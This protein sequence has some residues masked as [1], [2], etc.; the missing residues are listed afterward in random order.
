MPKK[1]N[2]LALSD[3]GED[4]DIVIQSKDED[5][6]E[7]EGL[8]EDEID[9]KSNPWIKA[10]S[11]QDILDINSEFYL[12][13]A[14]FQ[15]LSGEQRHFID[16]D[17]VRILQDDTTEMAD[18]KQLLITITSELRALTLASQ[19]GNCQD[20]FTDNPLDA[21]KARIPIDISA[22]ITSFKT[23]KLER[24]FVDMLILKQY[25]EEIRRF[26]EALQSKISV[27]VL[28]YEYDEKTKEGSYFTSILQKSVPLAKTPSGERRIPL[29]SY[30]FED[31][32]FSY[33]STNYAL[34]ENVSVLHDVKAEK[35]T[36]K[37]QNWIRKNCCRLTI[38]GKDFCGKESFRKDIKILIKSF[39][40]GVFEKNV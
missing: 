30:V 33:H 3:K 29:T 34:K 21:F 14:L 4:E 23:K 32:E 12:R 2:M 22:K 5:S 13:P 25:G 11:W 31:P 37:M 17:G 26:A 16:E 19:I 40:E 8:S 38:L 28:L 27:F 15:H 36:L 35:L 1:Q 9:A 39:Q 20:R 24:P 7:D 18:W 6:S 10:K